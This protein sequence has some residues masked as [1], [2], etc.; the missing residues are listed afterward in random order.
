MEINHLFPT[1]VA[2]FHLGRAFTIE[3]HDFLMS[4]ETRPNAG[5]TTSKDYLI[6]QKDEMRELNNFIIG[7]VNEYFR[8]IYDPMHD[9]SLRVTQSW[10]NYTNPGQYHHRHEH[11]NSLVSGVFY[12]NVDPAVDKIRFYDTKYYQINFLPR[13]WN[14]F[15]SRSWWFP[16][17]NGQLLL[18]PSSLTH[19]VEQKEG[20]NVRTSLAF[21]TF[22][23]G[24]IGDKMDMT[25]LDL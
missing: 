18:F 21:N 3:E 24:A 15:N 9:V 10:M 11:P 17:S 6:L 14:I 1:P 20:D 8:A 23:V 25:G 16:V 5:N 2:S 13:S 19:M 22:P 7:C 12:I 4:R